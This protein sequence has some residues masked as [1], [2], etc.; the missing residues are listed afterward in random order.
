MTLPHRLDPLL[1]PQSIA[2]VGASDRV[3]QPGNEILVNLY[4][5]EFT[6]AIYP[7]NPGRETAGGIACHP[8]LRSLPEVPDL[9]VFTVA[10]QRL[11]ACLDE[12]IALG[13]PAAAV[14]SALQLEDDG[15]PSL[16]QRV[17]DK[18]A[19]A[20]MLLHGGNCMG[21][22]N[23]VDRVWV[24]G[25]DTREHAH[26]GGVVLLSQSGAGMS[27]VLDCEERLDFSFA[28][29]TGQELCLAV[30][31]YLDFA[32]DQPQTRVVGLFLE[33]SRHPE[34]LI[35]ALEKA[36]RRAIPVVAIKVGKTELAAQ[37]A[38]SHS[39]ALAGSD[40]SY[41]AVFEAYGVQ[42]VDDMSELATALILFS[43]TPPLGE[44]ALVTLHDSGGE[45]QLAI[46][47]AGQL[48]VPLAKLAPETVERLEQFLDPGLPPV[49]PLD[50]W[51]SG[52]ADAPTNMTACFTALLQ[53]PGAALG[54]VVHDRAPGGGIYPAYLDY[55]RAAR[56]ATGKPVCLVANHQGSGSGPQVL[57]ATREGIPVVDGLRVF[58]V[59][60]RCLLAYRDFQAHT[61]DPP[62]APVADEVV[63]RWRRYLGDAQ[64]VP[65]IKAAELLRDF[66]ISVIEGIAIDGAGQ[67][68]DLAA[69]ITYPVVLKTASP[70]IAHKSD[71]GGVA[72]D[73]RNPQQLGDAYT[74][75]AQQLGPQALVAPMVT[76][77]GMEMILGIFRDAQFGP[78][79]VM[80]MGGIYAEAVQ[81]VIVLRPPFSA[82][83]ARTSLDGLHLRALL[84]GGRG[85]PQLALERFCEMAAR[86]SVMAV[87]LADHLVEVD[88]NPVRLMEDDCVGLDALVVP[89]PAAGLAPE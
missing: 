72:V 48:A 16:S 1:R 49:N 55:L 31:D 81:D 84:D 71:V 36:R 2:I 76:G 25:F 11:E 64:W 18:A 7:V 4:K 28:A 87:T 80:G 78:M 26:K 75:M 43:R 63:E 57:A 62:P 40:T 24:S 70:G 54:A 89:H 60:V 74:R 56:E 34:R 19:D 69:D 79:V 3:G 82:G 61:H 65:E 33:T 52:G 85:Q 21:F 15:K 67:L 46:D 30:E 53:D 37:L 23:F 59:G 45:R 58:L 39:G 50:A 44:G 32:L 42:R 10:D 17:R 27:G 73:L 5:G 6:G 13:V 88:I 20:G 22:Y 47:L 86:L 8:S 14:F 38:V 66:G 29:S 12:A 9:V 83:Q 77:A 68:L 41:Q 35:A 51:G